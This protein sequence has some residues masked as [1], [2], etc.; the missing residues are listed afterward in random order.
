M[1][2]QQTKRF[3]NLQAAVLR[4]DIAIARLLLG[5]T[6][7]RTPDERIDDSS[8]ELRGFVMTRLHKQVEVGRM[9]GFYSGSSGYA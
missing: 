3:R 5:S 2:K 6:D 9:V 7:W 4:G 1:N 8:G